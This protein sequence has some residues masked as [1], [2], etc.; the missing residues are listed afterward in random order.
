MEDNK[1]PT[2]DHAA[3]KETVKEV[4][5][6]FDEQ[7]EGENTRVLVIR[8]DNAK[9]VYEKDKIK[10]SGILDSPRLYLEK[11]IG[12]IIQTE[13]HV[14]VDREKMAI[15]LV[16]NEEDKFKH[17]IQGNLQLHPKFVE[18][19]INGMESYGTK[20]L[21]KFLKMNRYYFADKAEG[22]KLVN[23]LSNFEMKINKAVED[24]FS[25][26]GDR[27]QLREQFVTTNLP[28]AFSLRLPMFKGQPAQE[29]S[30]EIVIDPN[31][32]TCSFESPEAQ[33]LQEEVI[34]QAIDFE[35]HEIKNIAPELLIIE[36]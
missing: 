22:D 15:L 35:L 9:I 7:P 32:F 30:V 11:R 29:F 8:K 24:S 31:D 34:N 10:L 26:G 3:V 12:L 27:K 17:T 23:L 18:F 19:G 14:L 4:L 33:E 36:Q 1:Q 13:S 20:K 6:S 5:R 16:T 21:A 28:E 2:E 25:N